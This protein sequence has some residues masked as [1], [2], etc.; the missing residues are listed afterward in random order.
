ML[1][2]RRLLKSFRYAKQGI[3][4]VFREEQNFT[5]ELTIG[6]VAIVLAVFLNFNAVKWAIL[7]LTCGLVLVAELL[8]SAV[9]RVTDL[10]KP[11]LDVYV[12]EI[13]DIMAAAVFLAAGVSVLVGCCLFL[14]PL[15]N[16]FINIFQ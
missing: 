3:V 4:R 10:L 11:R 1:K 8:N 16:L 12:K 15:I 14:G 5:V 13:K 7:L 9:E 6:L 2:I